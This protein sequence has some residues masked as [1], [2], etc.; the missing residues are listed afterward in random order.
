MSLYQITLALLLATTRPLETYNLE[1]RATPSPTKQVICQHSDAETDD[2]GKKERDDFKENCDVNKEQQ[3]P[4]REETEKNERIPC[5]VWV[6]RHRSQSPSYNEQMKASHNNISFIQV[7]YP[8]KLPRC[9]RPK[10]RP[11][12]ISRH[13][14]NVFHQVA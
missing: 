9:Q 3:K 8:E 13:E 5:G 11:R 10:R 4:S 14:M 6:K 2:E 7:S 12:T 1:K